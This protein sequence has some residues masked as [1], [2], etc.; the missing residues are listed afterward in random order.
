[1]RCNLSVSPQCQYLTP[2]RRF[3]HTGD[4]NFNTGSGY[5]KRKSLLTV[6]RRRIRGASLPENI[7]RD[8]LYRLRNFSMVGNRVINRGDSIK[9]RSN[10]INSACSSR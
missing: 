1:M 3:S 6:P 7:G 9:S 2:P 5:Q 4:I 8:E 10:S